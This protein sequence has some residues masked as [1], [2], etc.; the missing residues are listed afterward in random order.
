MDETTTRWRLLA[1]NWQRKLTALFTLLFL[2]QF[3]S[4][5]AAEENLWWPETV[6]MVRVSLVA[7][8]AL[9]LLPRVNVWLLRCI[10]IW[11]LIAANAMFSGYTPVMY[12]VS[13]MGDF[14]SWVYD[15]FWQLHP[16][17]WFSLGAWLVYLTATWWMSVRWRIGAATVLSVLVLAA[18]DSFSLLTL[19]DETAMIILSG[20]LLLIVAHFSEIKR[21]NPSGWTYLVEYPATLIIMVC[22][23]LGVTMIPGTMMPTIRPLVTDP[24]TAYMHWKGKEAPSFGKSL[25][26]GI[27]STASSSSGYSRDDSSLGGGFDFDYAPVFSVETTHRSYWRGETRS[28]YTG[29]GWEMSDGDKQAAAGAAGLDI[30]LNKDS[31]F[32]TNLLRTVTVRQSVELLSEDESYPVLF[33]AFAISKIESMNGEKTGSDKLRWSPRQ[34]ELRWNESGKNS[35]PE[36]YTIESEMP[37]ATGDELKKAVNPPN[38]NQ[39]GEYLQLPR[40]LPVRVRQ[41][42]LDVTAG[43]STPYEKAELLRQYLQLNFAYTN[44]PKTELGKSSDF[45]DRFLFEIQEGYCDYFSSTM[46]VLSRSIG[47]PSRWVKGYVA[48]YNE[49]EDIPFGQVPVEILQNPDGPGTY[50]V[51]NSDAHSWVELYFHG[52]GWIPFEATSGFA[53][54]AVQQTE[55]TAPVVLPEVTPQAEATPAAAEV[56]E[57]GW[58]KA[59]G[60][61]AGV[62]AAL[63]LLLAAAGWIFRSRLPAIT[64]KGH[65]ITGSTANPRQR[66]VSEYGRLLKHYRR[67]GFAIPDHETARETIERLKQKDVWLSDDLEKLLVVFEKA[68]YSPR[69]VTAEESDR[70]IRI[71]DK[72]KKVV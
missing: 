35:Y 50:T 44:K 68:Q 55:E 4:W 16:Y 52:Y 71:V 21:L 34:S 19:W 32:N 40:D 6:T 57:S 41:L 46:A 15:N 39:F 31:R 29:S 63:V 72:L 69:S 5:F 56:K 47:I 59:A 24:Y 64:W 20:L 60:I 25:F 43:A 26:D 54:P 49:M 45:V 70:V 53:L 28:Y 37:V 3:V 9:E 13:S 67:R 36:S 22:L 10:Q 27:I 38:I 17:I 23:L 12:K 7:T 61:T 62:L 48:G 42:A 8:F 51:R 66:V 30:A 65:Q 1:D 11:I 2:L 58:G 18:R 33:G 14:G